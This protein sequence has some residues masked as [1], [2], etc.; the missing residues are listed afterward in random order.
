MRGPGGGRGGG[1]LVVGQR[2]RGTRP[3]GAA[4]ATPAVVGDRGAPPGAAGPAG[5]PGERRPAR[6]LGRPRGDGAAFVCGRQRR[7]RGDGGC[8]VRLDEKLLG[9]TR[10]VLDADVPRAGATA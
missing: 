8:G 4:V 6:L 7:A 2:A 1:D 9:R 5:A 3:A 10:R